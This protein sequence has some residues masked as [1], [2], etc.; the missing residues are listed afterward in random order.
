[1]KIIDELKV[2]KL[3]SGKTHEEL[4][5]EIGI[6]VFLISRL[7]NR[8]PK[9]IHAATRI[10]IETYLKQFKRHKNGVH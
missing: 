1:M 5:K 3:M 10:V 2:H 8:A 7:F 6:S 4:A 9:K